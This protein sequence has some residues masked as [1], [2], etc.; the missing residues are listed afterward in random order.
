MIHV[1][2]RQECLNESI[3]V[4]QRFLLIA[5]PEHSIISDAD[6]DGASA[7]VGILVQLELQYPVSRAEPL[8]RCVLQPERAACQGLALD[9]ERGKL[10]A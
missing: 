8:V 5:F 6:D 2:A 1:H 9:L 3:S 10:R 7:D 4:S